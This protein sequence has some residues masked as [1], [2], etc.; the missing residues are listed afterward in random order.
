MHAFVL[1]PCLVEA[2]SKNELYLFV[3]L[4]IKTQTKNPFLTRVTNQKQHADSLL[5]EPC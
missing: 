4:K 3:K 5:E 2:G 1:L